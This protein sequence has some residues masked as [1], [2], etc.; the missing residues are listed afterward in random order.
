MKK[1]IFLFWAIILTQNI[2]AQ[3]K[4]VLLIGTMHTVPKIVKNSY[5]PLLKRALK[6]TPEAIYVESP[7]ANDT[8]SWEYLKDGWSK[9]YKKFYFLADSL[10]QHFN[11]SSKQLNFLLKKDF[12]KLANQDLD[13]IINSFGYSRDYA[14]YK[15]SRNE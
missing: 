15:G 2:T 6:Y 13:V 11:F 8:I 9:N 1:Y 14:N 4:E 5:K 3:E 12:S 10:Q 7:R